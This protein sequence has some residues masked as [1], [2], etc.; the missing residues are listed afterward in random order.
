MAKS[1]TQTLQKKIW[2]HCDMF[3]EKG[4]HILSFSA[5]SSE[6]YFMD[7]LLMTEAC[8]DASDVSDAEN[9]DPWDLPHV[10]LELACFQFSFL[11]V[12]YILKLFCVVLP[13][14]YCEV[15]FPCM[16]GFCLYKL[17]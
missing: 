6:R 1:Y 17:S 9:R 5:N 12:G 10:I 14:S 8:S 11:P 3:S 2:A 15:M 13:E 4:L 7:K 16:Y